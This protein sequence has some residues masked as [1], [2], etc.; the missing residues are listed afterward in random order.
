MCGSA[1]STRCRRPIGCLIVIGH[2]SKKSPVVS[3]SFAK[4]DLH[5]KAC[6]GSWPPFWAPFFFLNGW[7]C[8]FYGKFSGWQYVFLGIFFF[9][10][11][12]DLSGSVP[13]KCNTIRSRLQFISVCC[14]VR[15]CVAV[16]FSV[17]PVEYQRDNADHCP[18][19]HSHDIYM[20]L[21]RLFLKLPVSAL[22]EWVAVYYNTLRCVAVR[23]S[24][25]HRRTDSS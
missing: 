25:W 10:S 8:G 12:R 18:I 23:S 17:L 7:Q 21:F 9:P 22:E 20:A 5:H 3:G 11:W 6:Y 4:N 19:S 14:S 13:E 16:R 15:Q 2:F 1:Y 24:V